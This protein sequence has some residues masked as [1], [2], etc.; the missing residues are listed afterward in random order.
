MDKFKINSH[1]MIYHLGRVDSWMKGEN[2][3]PIYMEVSPSN[4]CNYRCTFCA[5]DYREYKLCFLETVRFKNI[6]SELAQ[7]GVKSIMYA[8]EG[9]PFLHKD[10]AEIVRHTKEVGIDVA[11]ATNGA[12]LAP[13]IIDECLGSFSWVRFSIGGGCQETHEKIHQCPKDDFDKVMSNMAY[14]VKVRNEKKYPCALGF[15][16]LLLPEN[17]DEVFAFANLAKN[18]GVDYLVVKPFIKHLMSAHDIEKDF[19][20]ASFLSMEENLRKISDDKFNIILRTNII[21]KLE[22]PEREYKK[23]LGLPFFAEIAANGNVYTCGPHLG[24][25]KFCYGNIYENTFKEIWEGEKRKKVLEMVA[26]DLDVNTCMKSCRLDEVNRF[27][28][29]LKSPPSHVNFI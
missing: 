2:V 22:A 25:E 23:C 10:M 3:Y 18:L 19:H 6:L 17:K 20:Y 9:E 14:A 21:Q 7:L 12:L 26:K 4:A 11:M 24:N 8:G 29:E 15:Q 13:K 1:K 27:L 28:W 5:F 16:F